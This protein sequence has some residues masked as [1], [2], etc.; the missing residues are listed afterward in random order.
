MRY[1]M[2]AYK[3]AL[4]S[5]PLP[6]MSTGGAQGKESRVSTCWFCGK[7]ISPKSNGVDRHHLI[8]QRYFKPYPN[9]DPHDG[10]VV[11]ACVEH[12]RRFHQEY[13]NA[14]QPLDVFFAYMWQIDFGRNIYAEVG[15]AAD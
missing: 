9:E 1:T 3:R 10:N 6:V 15:M 12:H 5:F 4:L 2:R 11:L 8:A 14:R 7:P 13:D